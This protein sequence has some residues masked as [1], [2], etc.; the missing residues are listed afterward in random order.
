MSRQ[1]LILISVIIFSRCFSQN[2]SIDD[3]SYYQKNDQ[4]E[5]RFIF[6]A[7]SNNYRLK[8]DPEKVA[9]YNRMGKQFFA[10]SGALEGDLN[11]WLKPG[12]YNTFQWYLKD[13]FKEL[14]GEY[15]TIIKGQAVYLKGGPSNAFYSLFLAGL[16]RYKLDSRKKYPTFISITSG[17]LI[18]SG[19][20]LQSSAYRNY[21]DYQNSNNQNE[22]DL[23]F[24]KAQR[25]N[26]F[27]YLLL[28]PGITINV[29][30]FLTVLAEGFKN[31]KYN[32]RYE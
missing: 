2:V 22:I 13:N 14:N 21:I 9:L 16:G 19:I 20:Y 15:K 5:V 8:I 31:A 24:K 32:K 28:V 12:G 25:H 4:I 17:L 26:R 1:I 18:S 10:N 23:L 11:I 6:T 3:V 29:F 7:P 27:S 30:D